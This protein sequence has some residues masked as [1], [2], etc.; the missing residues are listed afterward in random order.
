MFWALGVQSAL[1][2]CGARRDYLPADFSDVP[3]AL[4]GESVLARRLVLVSAKRTLSFAM[5]VP[6]DHRRRPSGAV[7][8]AVDS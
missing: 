8:R 7:L 4:T 3:F 6:A 2:L 5:H 1:A